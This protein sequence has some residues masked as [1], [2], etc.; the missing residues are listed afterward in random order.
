MSKA[1]LGH[2]LD[3]ILCLGRFF[4]R[5]GKALSGFAGL[6]LPSGVSFGAHPLEFWT[7]RGSVRLHLRHFRE[8]TLD[9]FDLGN[10]GFSKWTPLLAA[11][12]SNGPP[13]AAPPV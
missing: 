8:V 4:A 11:T 2:V 7:A 12:F 5:D 9:A 13:A 1:L 10:I 3:S 6:N